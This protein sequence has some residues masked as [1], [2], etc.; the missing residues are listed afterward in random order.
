MTL[1]VVSHKASVARRQSSVNVVFTIVL[2]AGAVSAQE[3]PQLGTGL[4][5]GAPVQ[6]LRVPLEARVVKGAPYFADVITESVQTLGDGNRI[7]QRTTGRV[8][9]DSEG[10]VRREEDRGNGNPIVSITDPVAG[11]SYSLDPNSRVASKTPAPIGWQI[12]GNMAALHEVGQLVVKMGGRGGADGA[13]SGIQLEKLADAAK[14]LDA[15]K[16]KVAG[17]L[18]ERGRG[19]RGS[20]A[21][22]FVN[23]ESQ[24]EKVTRTM[25]GLKVDG[26][27]A[28]TTIPA[29]SIG[30][31]WPIIVESEEWKSPDLQV[32]VM[33]RHQD[34]RS[35]ETT[36][37]LV[38]IVRTEPAL[39]L[40]QVPADYTVR[41]T[42]IRGIPK[43]I[44]PRPRE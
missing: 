30:N 9:R 43:K 6:L 28:T 20:V 31:E 4:F 23:Q 25:E 11:V 16:A 37:R 36:Y 26:Y 44:A 27:R 3:I 24:S 32:F 7:S 5:A 14:A 12:M 33:T 38:N 22:Q 34:P 13:T 19:G 21:D 29:G 17:A 39:W 15:A 35:G 41:E 42:G 18:V 10:R 1:A 8:Y 40:F 2:L